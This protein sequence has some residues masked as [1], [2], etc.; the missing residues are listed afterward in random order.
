MIAILD[1]FFWKDENNWL[2]KLWFL[3]ISEASTNPI[4]KIQKFPL[5]MLIL[6]QNFF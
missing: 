3:K 6:R 1:I 5:G 4:L 2:L